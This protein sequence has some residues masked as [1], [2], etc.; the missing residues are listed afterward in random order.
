MML[1]KYLI[2]TQH[3]DS[4]QN[5]W[6]E[7]ADYW[8]SWPFVVFFRISRKMLRKVKFTLE[9]NTKAQKESR[10]EKY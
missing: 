6:L 2:A 5:N 7:Y 4:L 9:Q 1:R 3:Y 10:C 8:L